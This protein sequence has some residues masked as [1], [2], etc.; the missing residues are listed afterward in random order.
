MMYVAIP[1]KENGENVAVV[2]TSIPATAI[3]RE[4][5]NIYVKIFWGGVAI[6]I[7]A[8]GISWV[9][10]RRISKPI[11][12]MK[13]VAQGFTDGELNLRVPIPAPLEL[14]ELAKALNE[15]AKQLYE[16]IQTITK[17][18]NELEAVLSSMIEG[19]LAVDTDGHIMSVN[20][21]AAD[22]LK[23]N[24]TEALGRNVEEIV[25]NVDLHRFIQKT[26]ESKQLV[27][28]DILLP[29]NGNRYF[30]LHGVSLSD[31]EGHKSGAVIVLNDM[32]R[33]RRLENIR[34]DFVAN[35]SH[36]LRTP[37]TSIQGFIEALLEGKIQEPKQIE[38]YLKIIAKHS[39]R[40]NTIIDDLLS[41]S[42]LEED[43]EKRKVSFDQ[44]AL[45]PI[46]ASAM[47]LS[48]V[49]ATEK[50]IK[51]EL[52]C[53]D[54]IEA[55]VNVVFLEQ[56]IVNL[57]DNA[58]K[59][60]EPGAKIQVSV[61][62]GDTEMAIAVQDEGCGIDKTHLNR[63][64]ERFYVVD[65]GRSRKLGGTGLGLSIVKHIV[66]IHGGHVTVESKPGK[67]STFTIHLHTE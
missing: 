10:S 39:N 57:I 19:V 64:F 29:T 33:I 65:K 66:Q 51:V 42:R 23:I 13:Q 59:Y 17:Q 46:L 47:D 12:E 3:D 8:A 1:I 30:Q 18:R 36:E 56:A 7:C 48:S 49:K 21:A 40:L 32:T 6:A 34:R 9:I 2:R 14:S 38:R 61:Q 37:V 26:V 41:L 16:R 55:K 11:V 50:N 45:K 43:E 28:A 20:K 53:E 27:E 62:L 63:I 24:T 5:S 54:Q 25:R 60:S 22:L 15:M 52:D 4:L 35:V 58:I 44:V 67:G 31:S